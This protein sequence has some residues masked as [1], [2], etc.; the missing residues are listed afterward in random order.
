[1]TCARSEDSDQPGRSHIL[2]RAFAVRIKKPWVLSFLFSTQRRLSDSNDLL[3]QYRNKPSPVPD[4]CGC[5]SGPI[6]L[7]LWKAGP[8][9][10]LEVTS[11]SLFSPEKHYHEFHIEDF[12]SGKL[13]MISVDSNTSH[14]PTNW[15]F[16]GRLC[17]T[18]HNVMRWLNL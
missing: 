7:A 4:Y 12:P 14:T 6:Y 3:C 16:T 10:S 13:T 11:F 18:Y 17:D 1:M 5:R 2:I 9:D 8:K 15:A